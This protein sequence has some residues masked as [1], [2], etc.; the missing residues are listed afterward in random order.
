[1][2]CTK[3][4]DRTL[5]SLRLL[6]SKPFRNRTE[7]DARS[8]SGWKKNNETTI[9]RLSSTDF[10]TEKSEFTLERRNGNTRSRENRSSNKKC[11]RFHPVHCACVRSCMQFVSACVRFD[12]R[13][14]RRAAAAVV[15]TSY[16]RYDRMGCTVRRR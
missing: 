7:L 1:M 2:T 4:A 3:T 13:D 16:A 6:P 12:R 11:A 9:R 10:G 5:S 14:H 15:R 8:G